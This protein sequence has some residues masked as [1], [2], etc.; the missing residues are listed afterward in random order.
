MRAT[1]NGGENRLIARSAQGSAV[2]D[3]REFAW[4]V[5]R[6]RE[7]YHGSNPSVM[8][9]GS[10]DVIVADPAPLKWGLCFRRRP[11]NASC[12]G[13]TVLAAR[14]RPHDHSRGGISVRARRS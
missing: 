2:A 8:K 10:I 5:L 4:E 12:D 7:D 14:G 9:E 13:A 11:G 1:P 3:V 6:R